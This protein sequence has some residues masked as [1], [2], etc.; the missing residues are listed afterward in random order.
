VSSFTAVGH[1][2]VLSARNLVAVASG[3][4]G[5]G[6]LTAAVN[7]TRTSTTRDKHV[8]RVNI[9]VWRYSAPQMPWNMTLRSALS[10]SSYQ[11]RSTALRSCR[12][13]CLSRRA[14]WSTDERHGPVDS[15]F[16]IS[17]ELGVCS[18]IATGDPARTAQPPIGA[19]VPICGTGW[20]YGQKYLVDSGIAEAGLLMSCAGLSLRIIEMPVSSAVWTQ[21][22]CRPPASGKER[23]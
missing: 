22:C 2:S 18:Q 14:K 6:C 8:G 23:L 15:P 11:C 1:R 9:E 12:S 10:N 21:S 3:I 17:L 13:T 19:F 4:A 5:A 20:T 16:N 7:I